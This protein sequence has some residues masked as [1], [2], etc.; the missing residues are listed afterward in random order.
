[1]AIPVDD[2]KARYP[3]A[4]LFR[5]GDSPNLNAHILSLVRSGAKTVT[6]EAW[7]VFE[8]G[9]EAL[10][11]PGRIDIAL[12]WDGN[13]AYA[14]ETL[15]VRKVRF[16]DMAPDD[17][18]PQGE[19]RD[20]DDWANGYRRYLTRAGRFSPDVPLMVETF[21]LVEDFGGSA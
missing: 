1:M 6:C 7:S 2:A 12:D 9:G 18:P 15:D 19:F 17:I 14:V 11:E 5:P 8:T 3:G 16:C 13:A 21:R 4:E 20:Y 10:P